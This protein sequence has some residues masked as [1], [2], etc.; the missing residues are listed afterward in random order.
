VGSPGKPVFSWL[1]VDLNSYFASVEQQVH[2]ELRGHPVAIVPM[3]A[4]TTCCIAASYEAKAFG[5]KTGTQVGEAK[6]MCP[7]LILLVADHRLYT[8]YHHRIVNAVERAAPV[9]SVLSIDEMACHLIGRECELHNALFIGREVKAAIRAYAGDSLRCSVGLAPNRFLA[10]IASNMEKP[11]GLVALPPDLLDSALRTLTLRDLPGVGRS[12]ERR[13]NAQG[14][15]TMDQLMDLDRAAMGRIWGSVHGERMWHLLRGADF[16]G[17]SFFG[18]APDHA[19]SVSH[20]HVLAPD[21][22]NLDGAWGVA[23]K[24]LHKAAMRLRAAGLWAGRLTLYVRYAVPQSMARAQHSSGIPQLGWS[25]WTRFAEAQTNASLI[26]ALTELWQRR[27][28]GAEYERPFQVGLVL[29]EL[30]PDARHSFN[31]FENRE[32]EEQQGR[33]AKAMDRLNQRYGLTT[34]AP[35]AMLRTQEAAPTRISFT[36]IPDLFEDAAPLPDANALEHC[37]K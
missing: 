37:P 30:V 14:I 1:V 11:D 24:L 18:G 35:L 25:D 29:D 8:E 33:L 12:M 28:Q 15:H 22:R 4:D 32:E 20:S 6:Q 16:A 17:E 5:V 13:L 7:G 21:L 36:A 34:V 27:P 23:H 9:D 19:K 31:L 2:P 3:L 10:K 26:R